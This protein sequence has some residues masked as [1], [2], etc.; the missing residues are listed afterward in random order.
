MMKI[1]QQK[2]VTAV[3]VAGSGNTV[4][5]MRFVLRCALRRAPCAPSGLMTLHRC[6]GQVRAVL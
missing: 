6:A 1:D 4:R 3:N 2:L 5:A